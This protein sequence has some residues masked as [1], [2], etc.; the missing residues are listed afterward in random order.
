ME[1]KY[2]NPDFLN[3]E[4]LKTIKEH[5]LKEYN[6]SAALYDFLDKTFESNLLNEIKSYSFIA[7]DVPT[8]YRYKHANPGKLINDLFDS[9]DFQN[10]IS[11][12]FD[13][14]E[15]NVTV[16][17]IKIGKKDYTI[18]QD[19]ELEPPGIDFILNLSSDWYDEYG[20]YIAYTTKNQD[21]SLISSEYGVATIVNRKEGLMR[22]IKY[23]NSKA[24]VD[25]L[26][27]L[28]KLQL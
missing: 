5:L 15:F 13:I 16:E 12:I 9:F 17:V 28:A 24:M 3:T 25:R 8:K 20:G 4:N 7:K 11:K 2:I 18:L 1:I 19:E 22:Y 21:L 6:S 26:F 27:I 14:T 10:L 23:V